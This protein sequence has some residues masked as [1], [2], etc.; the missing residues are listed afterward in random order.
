MAETLA[1][2]IRSGVNSRAQFDHNHSEIHP[3]KADTISRV[4][5]A[6]QF[7]VGTGLGTPKKLSAGKPNKKKRR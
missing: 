6:S 1:A 7:P 3:S 4:F 2:T 5:Q